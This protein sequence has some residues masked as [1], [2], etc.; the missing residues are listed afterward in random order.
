MLPWCDQSAGSSNEEQSVQQP[1]ARGSSNPKY[2]GPA[3]KRA[4]FIN[5]KQQVKLAFTI[6]ARFPIIIIIYPLTARVVEAPQ[7]ISQTLCSTFPCSPLP[8][9]TW[10]TTGLSISWYCL[11]TSSSALSSSPVHCALQDGFGQVIYGVPTGVYIETAKAYMKSL[12]FQRMSVFYRGG[13]IWPPFTCAAEAGTKSVS[14]DKCSKPRQS[15][16]C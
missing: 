2:T 14:A 16:R 7:M 11:P 9:R 15:M 1:K 10:R 4:E 5:Q 8:S 13:I 6:Y 12:S 3:T